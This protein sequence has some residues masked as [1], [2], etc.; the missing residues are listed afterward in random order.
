MGDKVTSEIAAQNNFR[1]ERPEGWLLDSLATRGVSP[2]DVDIVLLTHLHGDHSGGSTRII[3]GQLVPTFPRAQYW[4]QQLEWIDAHHL[5]ERTRASY[6]GIN[7]D[8]LEQAGKLRLLNGEA[9]VTQGVRLAPAPGHTR[10]LQIVVIESGGQTAVF[11]G[12]AAF[13]HW[14]IEKL[15]WVSAYDMDPNTTIETKRLWQKWLAE[16]QALV[17]FQHDPLIMAGKLIMQNNRYQ[18]ETVLK[19]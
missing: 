17:I 18:V 12:D 6:Y 16:R 8:P 5:N 11:L 3:D 7:F 10:G 2:D 19:A 15:A 14:Q 9:S 1:L 13:F 4:V